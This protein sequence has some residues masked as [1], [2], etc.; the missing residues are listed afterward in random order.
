M[1]IRRIYTQMDDFGG[2]HTALYYDKESAN[3]YF[4]N[5]RAKHP[6]AYVVTEVLD[7]DTGEVI[8]RREFNKTDV[9]FE[10][11]KAMRQEYVSL[12]K[13]DIKWKE[14]TL[15]KENISPKEASLYMI[16]AA[17]SDGYG[18]EWVYIVKPCCFV[19]HVNFL[20]SVIDSNGHYL[21]CKGLY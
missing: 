7:D 10:E 20:D 12:F 21:S 14:E 8:E 16:D 5:V 19:T 11:V 15:V 1:K 13:Y 17:G 4:K 18:T 3:N 9:D 6:D 2:W